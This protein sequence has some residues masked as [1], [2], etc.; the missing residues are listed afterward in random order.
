VS[1]FKACDIRGVAGEQFDAP[2][3][4][5]VGRS[6]GRMM[7]ARDQLDVCV[8]GDFRSSTPKLKEM[9]IAGLMQAGARVTNVG[10]LPTP[11]IY[12]AARQ[13]G[14]RNVAI[15]T[16]SHNAGR[17]NGV[18]F[19]VDGWPA[20][21]K[22]MDELVDGLDD[23]PAR[24]RRGSPD[25]D[26]TQEPQQREIQND[27]EGTIAEQAATFCSGGSPALR[28]VLDTMAGAFTRIAPP[29]LRSAG[30]DV[31][32]LCG[33]IDPDFASREPNPAID[34]N[35]QPLVEAVG[36]HG[37]DL[38]IAFDGD[39][40]RVIFVDHRSHIVRPEQLGALLADRCFDRPTMVY[41]LKCASVLPRAVEAAGGT[42]V[43]QPS[44]H[45]FIKTTMIQSQAD[46]GVEVSG[47]HFYKAL[48]GGDDS[49]FTA[50]V[51]LNLLTNTQQPLADLIEPIGWPA[52][53]PDLRIPFAGDAPAAVEQIA[54][55]CGGCVLRLD[56]VRAEYD[57]GWALARA[58]IT[59]PAV[60]FRF[61][62]RNRNHLAQIAA[63]FL[64]TLPE[65]RATILEKIN[66]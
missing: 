11:M 28:V 18:K 61:E 17:Y 23:S 31:I 25:P 58:S 16:A 66:E 46:L 51:V 22:L 63:R 35:L 43:M 59:E 49:L 50:L 27:Y 4:Q 1:I 45:G 52:I 60:T 54:S 20:V 8:G 47:H 36:H 24:A 65:L 19:V 38:G 33:D 37:A 30:H 62:G 6:L 34:A 64:V 56:G 40:D 53:T 39:G 42:A 12:F 26:E 55:G 13:W 10:Q 44:G 9:L 5:R 29:I 7:L 14:F 21:P 41:D 57:D 15:V 48:A 32:S 2:M 3:A